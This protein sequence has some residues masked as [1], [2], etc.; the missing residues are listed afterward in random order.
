[1]KKLIL[2]FVFLQVLAIVFMFYKGFE[3]VYFGKE[4]KFRVTG[5]DPRDLFLGNFV[6]IKYLFDSDF[7]DEVAR[8]FNESNKDFKPKKAYISIKKADDEFYKFD[9]IS[10]KKPEAPFIQ[11]SYDGFSFTSVIEKYYTQKE[12]A[13]DL[14]SRLVGKD[15]V[16]RVMIM[17][18]GK[19][20]LVDLEILSNLNDE[21]T[22][23]EKED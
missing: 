13:L 1:M 4:Y 15:G 11:V 9:K 20:R 3:P 7:Y 19:A 21:R 16:A 18:N 5:I 17:D 22:I 8:D 14:E 6:S 12:L 23:Y 10:Y 2:P